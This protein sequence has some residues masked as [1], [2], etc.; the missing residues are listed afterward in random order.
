VAVL[1]AEHVVDKTL[2]A[3]SYAVAVVSVAML[4]LTV[5]VVQAQTAAA[6]SRQGLPVEYLEVPSAAMGRDVKI[7]FQGGGPHAVYLLDGLRAT[8]DASGW[9]FLLRLVP[10]GSR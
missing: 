4:A 9:E 2:S 10:A 3:W 8:D 1:V 5:S 6:Y 7:E